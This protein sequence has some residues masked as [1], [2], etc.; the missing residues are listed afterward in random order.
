MR[1][2]ERQDELELEKYEMAKLVEHY[3]DQEKQEKEIHWNRSR[4]YSQD[5]LQQKEFI[6]MERRIVWL[7][8]LKIKPP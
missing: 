6:E 1:N 5:L 8:F 4:K 7:L 2:K 3:K